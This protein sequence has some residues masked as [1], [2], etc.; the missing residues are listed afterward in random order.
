MSPTTQAPHLE[1]PSKPNFMVINGKVYNFDEL[2][3]SPQD[4]LHNIEA[5]YANDIASLK[6]EMAAHLSSE[7]RADLDIQIQRLERHQ[8]RTIISVPENLTENGTILYLD[9]N[10]VHETR[11]ILYKP[12]RISV[13]L[14]RVIA[15]ISW[16]NND[17]SRR[18]ADKYTKFI[19]AANTV[20]SLPRTRDLASIKIDIMVSQDIIIAPL[21]A[22]LLRDENKIKVTPINIHAHAFRDGDNKLCTNNVTAIAFWDDPNFMEN[23]NSLNPHSFANSDAPAARHYKSMLQNKYFQHLTIREENSPWRV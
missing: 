14:Q 22:S 20:I 15:F 12:H 21:I 11:L 6:Q 10:K 13:T 1:M 9:H 7:C 3:L 16:I 23:F 2:K 4:M 19:E 8:D 17:L 18:E 5:Y